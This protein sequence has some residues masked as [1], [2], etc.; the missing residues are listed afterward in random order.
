MWNLGAEHIA[1]HWFTPRTK[2]FQP[3]MNEI[4]PVAPVK[5]V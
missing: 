4:I 5:I 3:I 2:W 1:M